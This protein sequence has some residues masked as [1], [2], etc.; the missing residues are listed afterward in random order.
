MKQSAAGQHWVTQ[1][2]KTTQGL[3][4]GKIED[5]V[6]M[7]SDKLLVSEERNKSTLNFSSS[8]ALQ[9]KKTSKKSGS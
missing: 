6:Q 4:S 1:Y 7:L 9:G 2:L 5:R 3:F 8:E